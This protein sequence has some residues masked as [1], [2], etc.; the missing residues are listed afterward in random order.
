[1]FSP[2]VAQDT[3]QVGDPGGSTDYSISQTET[4]GNEVQKT[5]LNENTMNV[6]NNSSSNNT[7]LNITNGLVDP[8]IFVISSDANIKSINDAAKAVMNLLN[9]PLASNTPVT[10]E[11][12]SYKQ[13]EVMSD[14]DLL[15][16]IK[17]SQIII[18][19][20]LSATVDTRLWN[21]INLNTSILTNKDVIMLESPGADN[22]LTK[23]SRINNKNLFEGI[24]DTDIKSLRDAV[25]GSNI[26]ALNSKKA[27]W[28]DTSSSNYRPNA[29]QWIDLALY[30]TQKGQQ[31][32]EN[33]FKYAI[34]EYEIANGG[35]WNPAWGPQDYIVTQKEMIYRDG[36]TFTN[37]NDYLA[38]YSKN[39]NAGTVGL[40]DDVSYVL[41]GNMDHFK[42]MID[43]LT[44]KGLNVIPIVGSSGDSVHSSMVKYFTDPQNKINGIISF[45]DFAL[46]NNKT[47]QLLQDLNVPVY[48]AMR[49]DK[50]T[51][52]EWLVSQEGLPW[53]EVYYKIA[54]QE[55]QGIIEPTFLA[56]SEN[57]TDTVTGASISRF[58]PIPDRVE[59]VADRINNW[60]KLQK[61]NNTDKKIAMV[62]YNYPPGKQNIG[63]SYLNVPESI[64]N[65][66]QNLK[67]QGYNVGDIPN[68]E[69]ALVGN[70]TIR[71]INV[72][73]WAPGELEKLANDP[74][75]VL[76]DVEEYKAWFNTLDPIA[77]KEVIEGPTGYIEEITK[78]GISTG[79]KN[80]T[81]IA[82]DKWT[83]EM[84]SL[85]DT[86][87][88]KSSQ[89]NQ[90]INQMNTALKSVIDGD[91]SK[92]N[93][94]YTAK[95]QF[96]T[97]NMAGLSGW[98]D[99]PGN[100]MT[101]K[102]NGKDYIV[103]P[104]MYYGNVYMGPEPQ[105]GWEAD[106]AKLYHNTAVPP[107]HQYLAWYAW[108]NTK[109]GA[110]A[111]IHM[112]RHATYE[113]LP[114]KQVALTQFDYS[115]ITAGNTPSIYLYNMDGVGEGV[116]AKRRG[117]SVII[118]H[119]IPPMKSTE[120]YGGYVNLKSDVDWYQDHK[121]DDLPLLKAQY[122]ARIADVVNKLNLATELGIKDLNNL[123]DADM[124]K[125]HNY[126]EQMENTLIPIGLHTF[127]KQ[128]NSTEIEDLAN[129][130]VSVNGGTVDNYKKLI[131]DSFSNEMKS[132]LRS[133]NGSYVSPGTGNDPIRNNESLP[134]GRNF[135]SLN[136]N[137]LPTKDA[138]NLGKKLADMALAQY[139]SGKFPE[140]IAAVVWCVETSRDDG[141]MASFV[142]R[143]LGVEPEPTQKWLT[144]G[145]TGK[146][147]A[148]PL[149]TLLTDLNNERAKIGLAPVTERPRIDVITTTSGLFRDL[150]P[151]LLV[152]MDRSY[153]VALA[154]S[155]N[156][157]VN[158]PQNNDIK[159][160]LNYAI[161][162]L[163][164]ASYSTN[165]TFP[166]NIKCNDS[167]ESNYIAKHWIKT[168]RDLISK[169]IP[170]DQA[171]E[172]AITRIF[173]PPTGDY[174]AGVNKA[175]GQ[176]WTWNSTDQV[177]DLYLER[178]GHSYT[179][180]NWGTANT[181]LFKDLL[182][183][184][185][186]A[187]HSRSSNLYG[188]L[189]NDD[190]FDYFGGLS[191]GI[192]RANNGKAPDLKVLSYADKTN[193]KVMSLKEFMG[194]ELRTR[195]LNPQWIK[196]MMGEDYSGARELS[197]KFISNMKGWQITT[198]EIMENWMWDETV[199]TY[200]LD[201][202]NTGVTEWL[203]KGNNAYAMISFTGTL[204]EMAHKGYWKTD[205]ATLK[206]VA[207]KWAQTTI[208]SGV[209]CCDCSCGNLAMI[210]WATQYVNPDI[211]A[212]FN[213]QIYKATKNPSFAPSQ[214]NTQV[215]TG[216]TGSGQAYGKQVEAAN[217]NNPSSS[218]N[219]QQS[220]AGQSPGDQ[221][222]QKAYEVSKS[223]S[224]SSSSETGM[225][226]A[227]I[228]G[229]V[230]LIGL[231]G[232][233]YFRE[234]I[235]SFFRR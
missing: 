50:R 185:T 116:Q 177:A 175:L 176:S 46:G 53:N 36:K 34:K 195:Y 118:D 1:M 55:T 91:N 134:T 31:N 41:N 6:E 96:K 61:M 232:V 103:I 33:Q 80:A 141:T 164:R 171:G 38:Q 25:K 109:F 186:T 107:H 200:L 125:I 18:G 10:F 23:L 179:E 146:M 120:L 173:G 174:G 39:P 229:V 161:D 214:T 213:A 133:L 30:Y 196:G 168:V 211:L 121:N 22:N 169:G 201:Q 162:P 54:M 188:V 57:S 227:A 145:S 170:A 223:D 70:M 219:Q 142:L 137:Q 2:V 149:S 144:G 163:I 208:Q 165:G 62:Y 148:T 95:E 152:N 100:I 209:A 139:D 110:D 124:D 67:S 32:F 159:G 206:M 130:M 44:A 184:V 189:D 138:W 29:V 92:W 21:L 221:G 51:E 78:A 226:I 88:E 225:P 90:L 182:K 199:K 28:N 45:F 20:W 16:L 5:G 83:V 155:Y 192:K 205:D 7:Q 217:S 69:S 153:R 180:R 160:S 115:D 231:V 68:N 106:A 9:P 72:A 59:K 220:E 193:P 58:K 48:K 43:A 157:I 191:M 112:G 94:F 89:A 17:N 113:W 216:Q 19:E 56:S 122:K 119:L 228:I 86:F 12:R 97:L 104:G 111:Q 14:S 181:G 66:L 76:W 135:Y 151:K 42:A 197:N 126:L 79:S 172:L 156:T 52:G 75:T 166:T 63:A 132:L 129:I 4:D 140:K 99:V 27:Q 123:T 127:G 101:V 230:L 202:H 24:S 215:P 167:I 198:P 154:S 105:R 73:S 210:E 150:F 194:N 98:G 178:M 3:S 60:I 15:A 87:P 74:N 114:H 131:N 40:V 128:W 187:Y 26:T 222:Q 93:D 136:D 203:S 212:Q 108:I 77:K 84:K 117:Y 218:D 37:I 143:M 85:A 65:I 204:L 183:G 224:S 11:I 158:D 47:N 49:T 35:T 71:G 147:Q 8:K 234:D 81:K 102:K 82:I 190:F 207:N 13:V 64:L 233:G 235:L